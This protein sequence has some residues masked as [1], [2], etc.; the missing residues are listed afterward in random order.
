MRQV[1]INIHFLYNP[2][3][4]DLI[5]KPS[6]PIKLTFSNNFL[7]TTLKSN[8]KD[9]LTIIIL[10]HRKDVFLHQLKDWGDGVEE[11]NLERKLPYFLF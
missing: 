9:I 10:K 8:S 1:R 7:A 3:L 6:H 5:T 2:L 11:I 4:M